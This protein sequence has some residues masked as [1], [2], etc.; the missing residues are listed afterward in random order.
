[1]KNHRPP[2]IPST[3]VCTTRVRPLG[4]PALALLFLSGC[5][6]LIEPDIASDKVML[7][8]PADGNRSTVAVQGLQWSTVANAR[9]Y[10]VQVATPSFANP[11]RMVLDS[12]VKQPALTRTLKPGSYEWRV[13]AL[14]AGY[15]T[16]F[17]PARFAS[18]RRA[19]SAGKRCS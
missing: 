18:I 17:P 8:A 9:T 1:M 10:R 3:W 5:S 19:A 7:L 2:R 6:D 12:V 4:L 11:A 13:Q 16:A 15:A 14:N